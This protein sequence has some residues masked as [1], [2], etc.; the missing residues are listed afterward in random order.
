MFHTA[1]YSCYYFRNVPFSDTFSQ[2]SP[3]RFSLLE[4][5]KRSSDRLLSFHSMF[6]TPNSLFSSISQIPI[7]RKP[8][9][10]RSSPPQLI[11][12]HHQQ[13][14]PSNPLR[15]TIS[16]PYSPAPSQKPTTPA[17]ATATSTSPPTSSPS[18]PHTSPLP[19]LPSASST[20]PAAP[21]Y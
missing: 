20:T 4:T 18:P 17:P 11:P 3:R 8:Y 1:L 13:C 6:I 19:P 12:T 5:H 7:L 9:P 21:S 2:K 14:P 10:S 15:P 16:I